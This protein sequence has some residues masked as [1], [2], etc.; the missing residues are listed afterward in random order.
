MLF[1]KS[2]LYRFADLQRMGLVPNWPT[3]KRW[4]NQQGFPLGR[5]CGPNFRV[6]T[7]AQLN[8][9]FA[10]RPTGPAPLK[11][12]AKREGRKAKRGGRS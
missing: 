3:L 12:V 2:K 8:E 5:L 4:Q 9:W 10:N 6:W 11:G 7:G 1:D